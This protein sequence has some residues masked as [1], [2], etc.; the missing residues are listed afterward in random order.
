[1][2]QVESEQN[3]FDFVPI[4]QVWNAFRLANE[5][6]VSDS[7]GGC[8]V[9]AI[10]FSFLIFLFE[11]NSVEW[12][13][14]NPVIVN[15]VYLPVYLSHCVSKKSFKSFWM[16]TE[17]LD[18]LHWSVQ[19]VVIVTHTVNMNVS[20]RTLP[21]IRCYQKRRKLFA[22]GISDTLLRNNALC[23]LLMLKLCVCV[24]VYRFVSSKEKK[25][26]HQ[27]QKNQNEEEQ[28]Q[29]N[30]AWQY[31]RVY[32]CKPLKA[33]AIWVWDSITLTIPFPLNVSIYF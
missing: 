19:G 27:Q 31:S 2:I 28:N 11:S 25:K 8:R 23:L 15:E 21:R 30:R 3:S 10:K 24:Y 32:Q 26:K 20:R 7:A 16:R 17:P 22:D 6:D 5:N 1:M 4:N 29:I 14:V 33:Y 18:R 13:D 9:Y 12:I